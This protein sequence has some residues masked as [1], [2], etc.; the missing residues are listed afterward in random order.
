[1]L[2]VTIPLFKIQQCPEIYINPFTIAQD[3]T[4][5]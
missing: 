1:M 3:S 4:A 5:R 2:P